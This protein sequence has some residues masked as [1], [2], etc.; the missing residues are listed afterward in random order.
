MAN[1]AVN[2]MRATL[3]V[4]HLCGKMPEENSLLGLETSV[5]GAWRWYF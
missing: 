4:F 5:H 1:L 2:Y 3:L